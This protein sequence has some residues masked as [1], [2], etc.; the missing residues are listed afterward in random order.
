[1]KNELICQV[2]RSVSIPELELLFTFIESE[3]LLLLWIK[4]VVISVLEKEMRVKE[5]ET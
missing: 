3:L 1:M 2:L 4:H 5:A